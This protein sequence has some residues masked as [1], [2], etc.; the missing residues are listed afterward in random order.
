[1]RCRIGILFTFLKKFRT[2]QLVKK[3]IQRAAGTRDED[4]VRVFLYQEMEC[5]PVD[6]VW[7]KTTIVW[8][9]RSK[10]NCPMTVAVVHVAKFVSKIDNQT[11]PFKFQICI[12]FR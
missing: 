2:C 6:R 7:I 10:K 12:S 3:T 8:V 4:A 1:M 5:L 9:R 11:I